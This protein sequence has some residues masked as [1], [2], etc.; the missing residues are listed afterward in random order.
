MLPQPPV[1]PEALCSDV[2]FEGEPTHLKLVE[3]PH[4][5]AMRPLV[6]KKK[7]PFTPPFMLFAVTLNP[8]EAVALA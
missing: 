3:E 8:E 7:S 2:R 4:G 1:D 6:L 5:K